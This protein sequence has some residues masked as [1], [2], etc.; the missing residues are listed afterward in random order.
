MIDAFVISL[1]G[2]KSYSLNEVVKYAL[3]HA[4]YRSN[5]NIAMNPDTWNKLPEHLQK[6]ILDVYVEFEPTFTEI[7]IKGLVDAKKAFQE[8]GVEFI[9]FSP[10]DAERFMAIAYESEAQKYLAEIPDTATEYLKLVKAIK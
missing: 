7:K 10:A 6:L 5:A 9:S 4:L 8:S 2:A 1:D 3:E